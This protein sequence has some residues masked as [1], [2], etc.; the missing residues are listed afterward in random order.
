MKVLSRRNAAS[1]I[2]PHL[3]LKGR[4]GGAVID[5]GPHALIYIECQVELY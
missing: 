2:I 3:R 4:T 1:W 5:K